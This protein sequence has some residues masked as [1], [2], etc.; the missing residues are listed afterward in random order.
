MIEAK[1]ER[2]NF[3]ARENIQTDF[4]EVESFLHWYG[5]NMLVGKQDCLG[6]K[7]MAAPK[8]CRTLETQKCLRVMHSVIPFSIF[9]GIL[10]TIDI[11]CLGFQRIT[12]V[13]ISS[14]Q[15]KSVQQVQGLVQG[16]PVAFG[17]QINERRQAWTSIIAGE[18]SEQHL[19]ACASLKMF[20]SIHTNIFCF[21]LF[22]RSYTS[23][24]SA[25]PIY[26]EQIK[27]L[28]PHKASRTSPNLFSSWLTLVE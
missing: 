11:T 10:V 20:I 16:G 24:L 9:T 26:H 5:E 13:C 23:S 19:S 1:R 3:F 21:S 6:E 17:L 8:G 18:V 2:L 27:Q 22:K 7:E 4:L 14:N 25:L 12:Q 28:R 15:K